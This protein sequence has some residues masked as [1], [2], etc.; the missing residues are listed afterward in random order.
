VFGHSAAGNYGTVLYG[1]MRCV[2]EKL[3]CWESL[4]KELDGICG[5]AVQLSIHTV[6]RYDGYFC[7]CHGENLAFCG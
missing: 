4:I 7:V 5:T 1:L 3:K 6:Y 2:L